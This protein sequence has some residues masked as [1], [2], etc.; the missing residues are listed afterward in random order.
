MIKDAKFYMANLGA[1][2]S[3][4]AAA[5]QAGDDMRYQESLGRA[6]RTLA[7]VHEASRPEAYEEGLLMLRG[8]EYARASHSLV[9]F[10]AHID[11]FCAPILAS[12]MH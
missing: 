10:R 8:L 7:F 3:R 4:C 1:D 9:M 11:D 2:I 12:M 5:A 6:Y